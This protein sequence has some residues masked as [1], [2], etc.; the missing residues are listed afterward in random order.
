[1]TGSGVVA[2]SGAGPACTAVVSMLKRAAKAVR[3]RTRRKRRTFMQTILGGV[4]DAKTRHPG[5]RHEPSA[6]LP[7]R[8]PVKLL[9]HLVLHG[10]A[11]ALRG[12]STVA[13]VL[14]VL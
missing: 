7:L 9:H 8:S 1:M 11:V 10:E 4:Y 12:K 5:T 6:S 3:L 2:G 13:H 14:R